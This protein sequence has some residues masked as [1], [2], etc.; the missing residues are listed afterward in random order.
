MSSL[1]FRPRP[2]RERSTA[3]PLGVL[4]CAALSVG[5]GLVHLEVMPSHW[6]SWWGYGVFFLLTGTGQVLYAVLLVRRPTPAVAAL[7]IVGNLLIVATYLLSRTNG[8]PWGPHAG[9]ADEVGLGDFLTTAGE[10]LL[11]G[12]L[13][14]F[15]GARAAHRT[16]TAL[17]VAGVA[18]W[19][20]RLN[21]ILL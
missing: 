19:L 4:V 11:V 14:G 7:G 2:A 18:M 6:A 12:L 20:A 8:L 16:M 10:V 17:M 21:G 15:L 5:A 9:R 13:V 1:V 3:L